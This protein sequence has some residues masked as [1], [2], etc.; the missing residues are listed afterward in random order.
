MSCNQ[1]INVFKKSEARLR[2]KMKANWKICGK[3]AQQN[4]C[5]CVCPQGGK[6]FSF[7]E[8]AFS[9]R[10]TLRPPL[11]FVSNLLFPS[12]SLLIVI[13][14]YEKERE[15]AYRHYMPWKNQQMCVFA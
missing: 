8:F 11:L 1:T 5:V 6:F 15:N 7:A 4:V 13:G 9:I 2:N 12:Y 10:E 3:Y 14:I